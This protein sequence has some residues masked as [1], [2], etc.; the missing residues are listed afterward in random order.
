MSS[1]G[2]TLIHVS[3]QRQ[4]TISCI[5]PLYTGY[6]KMFSRYELGKET[7]HVQQSGLENMT[8]S[9]GVVMQSQ[10]YGSI[11]NKYMLG[12]D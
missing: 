11:R 9:A 4:A 5:A 8:A 3:F 12:F 10:S 7:K 6:V 2:T 1:L